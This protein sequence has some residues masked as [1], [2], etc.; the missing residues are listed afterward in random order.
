[1]TGSKEIFT[2]SL[3]FIKGSSVPQEKKVSTNQDLTQDSRKELR[4]SAEVLHL[5]IMNCLVLEETMNYLKVL[6]TWTL[7]DYYQKLI[8]K[9]KH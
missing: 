4:T 1:M 8:L 9:G 5:S 3:R 7:L 2:R 6:N